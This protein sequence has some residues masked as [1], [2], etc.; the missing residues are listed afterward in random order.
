[1]Q[2]L[3]TAQRQLWFQVALLDA[4]IPGTLPVLNRACVEAGLK[5]A[6]ALNCTINEISTFDRKH[7]FYS[8]L[9]SGYQVYLNGNIN[10]LDIEYV[11]MF[12]RSHNKGIQLPKRVDWIFKF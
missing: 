5:T 12:Y 2:V 9:P 8:D 4:S 1:M 7:Y 11:K 3:L 6:L 10:C